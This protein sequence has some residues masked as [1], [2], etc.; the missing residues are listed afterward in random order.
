MRAAFLMVFLAMSSLAQSFTGTI[1]GTARDQSGAVLPGVNITVRNVQT[2]LTRNALTNETGNYVVPLLPPGI[3]EAK[4]ELTGFKTEVRSNLEL[5]VDDRLRVD[6][7]LQVGEVT[8]RLVVTEAAPLV[9]SES[10]TLGNVIDRQKVV[11]LPLNGR[12]FTSLALLA[13]GTVAPAPGSSL[14]F[15]GGFNVAGARETSNTFTIDGVDNNDMS[16]NGPSYQPSVEIIQEFKIQTNS[17]SA[18]YGRGGGGQI[19]VTTKQGTNELHGSA[20]EFLR[21]DALDAKN[22]FDSAADKIPAFRR[23][24]YGATVGGPI[25]KDRTFFFF[26]W[27]GL[28]RRQART[29]AGSVPSLEFRNGDFSSLLPQTVIRDPL[30]GQA[31]VDNRI[32]ANRIDPVTRELMKL[33]PLPN[34]SDPV[35]NFVGTPKET[36]NFDQFNVRLDHRFSDKDTLLGRFGIHDDTSFFPFGNLGQTQGLPGF[37]R[38]DELRTRHVTISWTH[39]FNPSI[40]AEARV[41]FSRLRQPRIQEGKRVFKDFVKN[42]GLNGLDANEINFGTPRVT[43]TGFDFIGDPTNLPQDRADNTYQWIYNVSITKSNHAVKAGA[44]IRRLQENLLLNGTARGQFDFTNRYT[45][46][47]A[48]DFLLGF[49][50]RSSRTTNFQNIFERQT[51]N[52]FYVQDDWKVSPKLTVNLGLRYEYNTPVKERF[53]RFSAFDTK[54][55]QIVVQGKVPGTGGVYRS[56]WN[57]FAPRAGFAYR[58]Q[59]KTAVRLGYGIFTDVFIVGNNFLQLALNFPFRIP[60]TFTAG[61]TPQISLSRDP[62]PT[63]LSSA[64]ISPSSADPDFR[65][66]YVQNWNFTV[67]RELPANMVVE[68]AYLASK[69]TKLL[70]TRDINQATPGAGAVGPRRPF[71]GFGGISQR[72]SAGNSIYH[73]LQLRFEKRFSHG[74]SFLSAYTFGRAIDLASSGGDSVQDTRNLRAER[75]LADFHTKHRWVFNYIYELPF[76][77]GKRYGASHSGLVGR[78]ISGWQINGI[79]TLQAGRPLTANLTGDNAN[80]GRSGTD[81]PNLVGNSRLSGD[82]RSPDGWFDRGAFTIP[83]PFTFGNAGRNTLIGPGLSNLDFSVVKNNRWRENYNVQFRAEFFNVANHPNFDQPNRSV[84]SPQFGKIFAT[85]GFSRQIQ[86]GI[87]VLY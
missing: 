47:A 42:V 18:E 71:Q 73:A 4:A 12:E 86:F 36:Q 58:L 77:P 37:G 19:V 67:E 49:P 50:F 32:P 9:Q 44:D 70:T 48:A 46:H 87:K 84:N 72:E 64:S 66:G 65:D 24:Q 45:G 5:R 7:S 54:T 55:G 2:N 52:N 30:T 14:S 3:Y 34:N 17:Y 75:G 35:R 79:T 1:V 56:D 53:G 85:N 60:E 80:T 29:S 16:I 31:F 76:G 59:D 57:N 38:D 40:I 68:A 39:I 51:H 69:G 63:V 15:R 83:A 10:A 41:G 61:N 25:K 22:F 28:R 27:E 43:I 62:F 23:N 26:G 33:Y 13:P 78:L 74:L 8:E 82:R 21:N 81:H 20:F 6:F 11:E